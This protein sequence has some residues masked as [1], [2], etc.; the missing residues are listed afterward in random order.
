MGLAGA[1]GVPTFPPAVKG[2][3]FGRRARKGLGGA[4][5]PESVGE[6]GFGEVQ[7]FQ[8]IGGQAGISGFFVE[9]A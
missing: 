1:P 9:K 8:Q 3:G 4:E 7:A 6:I 2:S 5:M